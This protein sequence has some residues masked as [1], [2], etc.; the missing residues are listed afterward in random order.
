MVR[1]Y[2]RK[3][4]GQLTTDPENFADPE[5]FEPFRPSKG[6]NAEQDKIQTRPTGTEADRNVLRNRQTPEQL[7]VIAR[8]GQLRQQQQVQKE[9]DQAQQNL[10]S[11]EQKAL[12]ETQTAQTQQSNQEIAQ[13]TTPQPT[14]PLEQRQAEA[15]IN[16]LQ[17]GLQTASNIAT[18][19]LGN[20]IPNAL[21][22]T[23]ASIPPDL[24]Q[25]K[26]FQPTFQAIAK[27][28]NARIPYFGSVASI[29]NNNG[30]KARD[31]KSEANKL[32]NFANVDAQRVKSGGLGVDDALINLDTYES[33]VRAKYAEAERFLEESPQDIEDGTEYKI[34]MANALLKIQRRREALNRLK[35][36]GNLNQYSMEVGQLDAEDLTALGE[37][38][39]D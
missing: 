21:G 14:A 37:S 2:K 8:E 12:Q 4:S 1:L 23:P 5:N 20:I 13:L 24:A 39:N 26:A 3:N 32:A 27:L 17:S 10:L 6:F 11:P 28:G 15:G 7:N 9:Q 34:D 29:F 36:S 19:G 16:I 18:L 33:G 22:L 30:K 31:L 38:G 25:N 35:L